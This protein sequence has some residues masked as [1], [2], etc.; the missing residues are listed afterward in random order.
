[1]FLSA[2]VAV[3]LVVAVPASPAAADSHRT[4]FTVPFEYGTDERHDAYDYRQTTDLT[5]DRDVTVG[6][7]SFGWLSDAVRFRTTETTTNNDWY[8]SPVW[9]T[10]P[11]HTGSPERPDEDGGALHDAY[12]GLAIPIDADRYTHLSMRFH[13]DTDPGLMYLSWF[14]CQEWLPECRGIMSLNVERGWNTVDVP[15]ER[16]V[17]GSGLPQAW[18][19]QI[20][21]VRL[22]GVAETQSTFTLDWFRLYEGGRPEH[23][24][25]VQA[26]AHRFTYGR[27]S[28]P[29]QSMGPLRGRPNHDGT[30]QVDV[31]GLPP[32]TWYVFKDDMEVG[33]ATITPRPSP[34]VID[35]D[36]AG[37]A[38]YATEVLGNP[39]DFNDSSDVAAVRNSANV[40]FSGGELSA[41]SVTT[42]AAPRGNDPYIV[43]P[44]ADDG[45][46]P[47]HYHRITVDQ[48]YDAPFN[49]NDAQ[50]P[51]NPR[52]GGSHGRLVWRTPNHNGTGTD[53]RYY[54]DGREF[55]FFKTWDVYTYD[56]KNVP[57]A[58]GMDSSAE[59]N[60]GVQG[61]D[62]PDPHWTGNGALTFL[63]FDPHE[64]PDDYR[65]YLRDLKIAADDAADPTFDIRWRDHGGVAGTQV[66]V[67][68][69]SNRSGYDGEVLYRGP[70]QSGVNSTT[71]DATDRLPGT[72][73]VSI[74]STAPDGSVGHDYAT[75]P[76]QVSPRIAGSDRIATS[77]EVSEQSF[78]A[79]R[80]A[81][82]ASARDFPDALVAVQL[83]DAV[84][85]PVLLT[86]PSSLP[87][88]V[89]DELDRLGVREVVVAGGETAINA[90]VAGALGGNGRT[91]TRLGGATRYE[92]SIEIAR[93]TMRRRGT[94]GA[95]RVLV[96]TGENFP[97]AL[98][99]G[100]LVGHGDLPLVL[101]R[102]E[103]P[104]LP[105][106]P[107]GEQPPPP[108]LPDNGPAKAFLDAVGASQATFVGGPHAL[109]DRVVADVRGS[110]NADRIAGGDRFDTARR[111]TA[112]AVDAGGSKQHVLVATGRNFPDA[113]SAGPAALARGGVLALTEKD[114]V[115]SA[116]RDWLASVGAWSSWR[117]VG[118][119]VAVSHATVRSL[120]STSGL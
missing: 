62:G 34:E 54:S 81:V 52:P 78:D 85:G 36:M 51:T 66:T 58:Q 27:S 119:H 101:A 49:L 118:G 37:G 7:E 41:Q 18:E 72:Y 79:A 44:L 92:T 3:P 56:M 109:S 77:V 47:V 80:T 87:G 113:L 105:P 115:P 93:E 2:L 31:G 70:Q 16:G 57:T 86:E 116:T 33:R 108:P 14:G 50:T 73:W 13:V 26:E 39:W 74:T 30:M 8:V 89:T 71:F 21:G 11:H 95:P 69:D 96:T 94:S 67:R 53:C 90:K 5:T 35:P 65:W 112:A 22:Q 43:L 17:P 103:A 60:I 84:E 91:V 99:A 111:L 19:G 25:T 48:H 29:S 88:S 61:C 42:T 6:I 110:R 10:F 4:E 38:D 114:S 15:I 46:D 83:A 55:V 32:G 106:G 107:D 104:P 76:L 28:D 63:R 100:P 75:G 64:A 82:V 20:Y 40:Q 117:V 1:M 9:M 98:A 102:P 97:D 59:P 23:E 120:R 12:D 45:L 68:L 24:L